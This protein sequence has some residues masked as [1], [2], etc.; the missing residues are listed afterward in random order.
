[1]KSAN[2]SATVE[3]IVAKRI[4]SALALVRVVILARLH[5]RRVQI[6]VVRHHRRAED[7]DGDVEHLRVARRSSARGMK[8]ASIGA[9]SRLRE[10]E[11]DGERSGDEQD[12]GDDERFDVAKA[13]ILQIEHDQHV[14]RRS[15]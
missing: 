10:I 14:E 4:A 1:M 13:A 11:L 3:S 8:P 6:Q 5:D 12:Q 7:A 2:I 9:E 15:G